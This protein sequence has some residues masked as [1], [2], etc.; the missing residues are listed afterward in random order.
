MSLFV[1]NL[2][3]NFWKKLDWVE[4]VHSTVFKSHLLIGDFPLNLWT[5]SFIFGSKWLTGIKS[6]GIAPVDPFRLQMQ[7]ELWRLRCRFFRAY[8]WAK[9]KHLLSVLYLSS[10]RLG[11]LSQYLTRYSSVKQ[12]FKTRISCWLLQNHQTQVI[13]SF[14]LTDHGRSSWADRLC[15]SLKHLTLNHVTHYYSCFW[16]QIQR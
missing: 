6:F 4:S 15:F 7:N 14:C 12:F 8:V 3:L 1:F 9:S 13:T 5:F 10:D 11:L 2:W 16:G